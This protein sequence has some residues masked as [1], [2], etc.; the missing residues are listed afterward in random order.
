MS[1]QYRQIT[2]V[3]VS[4]KNP[5]SFDFAWIDPHSQLYYL[6]DRTNSG[7]DIID[8]SHRF[9][10]TISGFVGFTGS[11]LNSGP[12]GIEVIPGLGQIWA[13]DGN[14]SAKVIDA[15]TNKIITSIATGGMNRVD[16][17]GYDSKDQ[18][19]LLCNDRDDPPFATFVS[20]KDFK[21]LGK[22]TYPKGTHGP[23][24]PVWNSHD[25]KFYLAVPETPKNHGGQIDVIDPV[26]MGV[27]NVYP[28][29]DCMPAGLALGP[30]Q[31]LAVACG[32]GAIEA[33]MKARTYIMDVRDGKMIETISQIGGVD[34]AWYNPG[35]NRF[36]VAA[37]GMTSDGTSAGSPTPSVGVIDAKT[38][39]WITNIST[40]RGAHSVAVNPKNNHVFVPIKG[41]GIAV[42]AEVGSS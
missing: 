17:V 12:N 19:M 11:P 39:K 23:E 34:Q 4:P 18:V 36:Y 16:M 14:S 31:N 10:S 26:S 1:T 5:E 33:G 3:N 32:S 8:A 35:D 13:G 25:G 38:N 28:L 20:T 7:V 27:V 30:N 22:I 15:K 24:H 37:S 42:Y 9:L 6:T 2:T 21:T 40:G 29:T 41:G